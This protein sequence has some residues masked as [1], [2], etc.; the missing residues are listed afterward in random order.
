MSDY[1]ILIQDMMFYFN[2]QILPPYLVLVPKS[3]QIIVTAAAEYYKEFSLC[4]I[5]SEL[6]KEESTRFQYEIHFANGYTYGEIGK[7][8]IW[9]EN[10]LFKKIIFQDTSKI[11]YQSNNTKNAWENFLTVLSERWNVDISIIQEQLNL[12]YGDTI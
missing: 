1:Y 12:V 4:V 2:T 7:V 9:F 5:K 8:Q 3:I 10:K 6:N 11:K